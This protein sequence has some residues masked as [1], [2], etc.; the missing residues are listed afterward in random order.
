MLLLNLRD[1]L[2]P[3]LQNMASQEAPCMDYLFL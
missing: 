2:T 1:P 3:I